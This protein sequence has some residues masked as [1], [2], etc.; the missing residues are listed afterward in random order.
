[1]V[2]RR[3]IDAFL[4]PEHTKAT[5][6]G[7][8]EEKKENTFGLS[9]RK[10]GGGHLQLPKKKLQGEGR[11]KTLRRKEGGQKAA[12][13]TSLVNLG[14]EWR[15]RENRKNLPRGEGKRTGYSTVTRGGAHSKEEKK[16]KMRIKVDILR[17][18]GKRKKTLNR[19]LST[20]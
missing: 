16:K 5:T 13:S 20:A 12:Q 8:G 7:R 11:S 2:R 6:G 15:R 17:R 19:P 9:Y 4:V 14:Q 18:S 3:A 1:V 10:R